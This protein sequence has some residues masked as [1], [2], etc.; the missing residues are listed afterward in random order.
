MLAASRSLEG[1]VE[2]WTDADTD[3]GFNPSSPSSV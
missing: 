1:G 3:G 2:S